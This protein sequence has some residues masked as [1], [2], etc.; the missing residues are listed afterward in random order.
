MN[1]DSPE[2]KPPPEA[3]LPAALSQGAPRA[4]FAFEC[5]IAGHEG[6]S[7]FNA[8][9]RA[10]AKSEFLRNIG[11]CLPD[12]RF[13]DLR[14]RKLGGPVTS[15][16]FRRTAA[17]RGMPHVRCGQ[18]VRVGDSS[19]AIVGVNESANFD[20]LFDGPGPRY[21]RVLNVHPGDVELAA[22]AEAP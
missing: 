20:V 6:A 18:R 5:R 21:G 3:D 4:I 19:G 13:T 2:V 10:Q 14:A 7:I 9:T 16:T 1:I 11:D 22:P 17:Y 15:E 12:V 8:W